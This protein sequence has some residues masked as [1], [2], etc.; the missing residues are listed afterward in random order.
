[1]ASTIV[2]FSAAPAGRQPSRYVAAC[3]LSALG[4]LGACDRADVPPSPG[5][6]ARPQTMASGQA[7]PAPD[8]PSVQRAIFTYAR[9]PET[10]SPSSSPSLMPKAADEKCCRLQV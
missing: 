3:L 10:D 2:K 7:A 5:G 1:M 9:P 8:A 6:P 4:L